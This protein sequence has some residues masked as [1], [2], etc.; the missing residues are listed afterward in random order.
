MSKTTTSMC[1][2]AL[3]AICSSILSCGGNVKVETAG[4]AG[5]G[6]SNGGAGN[7]G[8]GNGAG[9]NGGQGPGGSTGSGTLPVPQDE[10]EAV[11]QQKCPLIAAQPHRCITLTTGGSV[12]AVSPDT[13]QTCVVGDLEGPI[14]PDANS[15]AVI[16]DMLHVC[17]HDSGL[18]R[19]KVAGGP[20]ESAPLECDAVSQYTGQL[21]VFTLGSPTPVLLVYPSWEAV[22]SQAPNTKIP[23]ESGQFSRMTAR[24]DTL[25]TAW[26]STDHLD[27]FDLPT[28]KSKGAL[29]L[30]GFD[31]WIE[32]L[33][34]TTDDRIFI[35]GD[36]AGSSLLGFDAKT[37][38]QKSAVTLEGLNEGL[39]C[40]P[41]P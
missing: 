38:L 18:L 7:G 20:I 8:A 36:I 32:G 2:I 19:A 41:H 9:G 40:W 24:A 1:A 39:S 33:D 31:D 15:I 28:G 22:K 4:T 37:G 25:W 26:H 13:G 12:V 23:L 27:V 3:T 6:S 11:V 21:V 16:G 29:V 5:G 17:G 30:D 35:L 14:P 10:A 34:I